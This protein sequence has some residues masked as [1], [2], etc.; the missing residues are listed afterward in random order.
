MRSNKVRE[1]VYKYARQISSTQ[2]TQQAVGEL[3]QLF[4]NIHAKEIDGIL[5]KIKKGL[6]RFKKHGPWN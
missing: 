6:P 1:E 5:L 3:Y 4:I 2:P